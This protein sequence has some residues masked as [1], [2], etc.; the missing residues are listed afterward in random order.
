MLGVSTNNISR[1]KKAF[2][3]SN[4]YTIVHDIGDTV[5]ISDEVVIIAESP[6]VPRVPG[7]DTDG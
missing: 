6:I 4:I 2:S 1:V 7:P 5:T 3:T